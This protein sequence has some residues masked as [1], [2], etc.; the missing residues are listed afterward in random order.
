M[1]LSRYLVGF[2]VTAVLSFAVCFSVNNIFPLSNYMD[3]IALGIV[4]FGTI[5]LLVYWLSIR[6]S[7]TKD[8]NF[9]TYVILINLFIK[10]ISSFVVV[11]IYASLTKPPNKYY[12]VNFTIIY[13]LFT[14]FETYFLSKQA[15]VK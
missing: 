6:A 9:F 7:A 11:A 12:L 14:I 15:K 4:M 1:D 2:V 3:M 5:S 13:L 10:V 8:R